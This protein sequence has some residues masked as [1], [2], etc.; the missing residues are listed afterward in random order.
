MKSMSPWRFALQHTYV[1]STN[2]PDFSLLQWARFMW[3]N[4]FA[5][6]L[7]TRASNELL[8]TAAWVAIDK[9]RRPYVNILHFSSGY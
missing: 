8:R 5:L 1:N 9:V 3:L 7:R 6:H 2:G 4:F